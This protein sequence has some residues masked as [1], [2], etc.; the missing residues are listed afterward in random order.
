MQPDEAIKEM[1]TCFTDITNNLKSLGKTYTDE[2]M[3]KKILWC[4]PKNKC[5][6]KVTAIEEIQD[7]KTPALDDLL[8]K[9]LTDEIHPKED[10]EGAQQKEE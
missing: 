10:E 1:L 5:G 4:L 3:V 6:L 7:L 8:G 9:L 2:E